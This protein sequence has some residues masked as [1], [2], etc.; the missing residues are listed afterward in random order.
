[1]FAERHPSIERIALSSLIVSS[2]KCSYTEGLFT[3]A[4]QFYEGFVLRF[5]KAS[6]VTIG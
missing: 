3:E 2:A 5:A 6:V 1:M 4:S